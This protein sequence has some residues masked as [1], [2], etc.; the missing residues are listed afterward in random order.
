MD[1]KDLV[2]RFGFWQDQ[3][4]KC[5]KCYGCRDVCPMC[6]CNECSLECEDL[7]KKGSLPVEVPVFHLTRAMHMADRCVDCG[8]CDEACPSDIPLRLLYK[9][10]AQIMNAEFGFTSGL[11]KNEKSPL[12][13]MGP[14]K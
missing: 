1:A 2:E 3:F 7:V 9:K 11:N 8:L 12:S 6:F 10:T 14:A 13:T 5:I 4:L